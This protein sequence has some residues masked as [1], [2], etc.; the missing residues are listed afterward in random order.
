[1]RQDMTRSEAE[2]ALGLPERYGMADVRRAFKGRA[3]RYH[4]DNARR[5]G[6]SETFAQQK[7]TEVNK[8]YALLRHLFDDGSVKTLRRDSSGGTYGK[9]SA[10]VHHA[11]AAR[12]RSAVR[13]QVDDSL[14]WDEDG[15]PR[16]TTAENEANAAADA[17]GHTLRRFLLGPVF[18]RLVFIAVL[19]LMWWRTFPFVGENAVHFD[20]GAQVPLRNLVPVLMAVVYPSYF[21]LYEVITGNISGVFRELING[22]VS[23]ITRTHIEVRKK[24]SYRSSLSSLLRDQIYSVLELPLAVWLFA[25]GSDLPSSIEQTVSFALG[26]IVTLDALIGF[27]GSGAAQ[28]LSRWLSGIV[29][30]RY[31]TMRMNLLKRCGQWASDR[32]AS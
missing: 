16:S 12:S 32:Y 14:F 11:P 1:M 18:L 10:G 20:M 26:A 30:R 15:N 9:H 28:G 22:V 7:M 3:Q 27:F 2:R 17:S 24:G 5:N 19:A 25:R 23:I 8:A 29:E 6:F 21:L 4:P 31:V 13:T